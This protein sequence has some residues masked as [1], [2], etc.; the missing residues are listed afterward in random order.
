MS[1]DNLEVYKSFFGQRARQ[2]E[3]YGNSVFAD[4]DRNIEN[5]ETLE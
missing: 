1:L 3:I 5:D 4:V 2:E